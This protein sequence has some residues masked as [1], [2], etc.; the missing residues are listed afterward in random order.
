MA[1][2]IRL[3]RIG[4]KKA[5]CYRIIAVD[6][7]KK[8]DGQY[9]DNLGTYEA[10]TGNFVQLKQDRIDYWI[11]QGA[12]LTD[13]AKKLVKLSK[14]DKLVEKKVKKQVEPIEVKQEVKKVQVKTVKEKK[15]EAAQ[16]EKE[17]PVEE[18]KA[19]S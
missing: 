2:K 13:S 11:S 1:V 12:Q 3:S 6:S 7:R 16:V 10:L 15:E 9:L 19:E 17:A 8:R 18:V 14:Q 5:P 4:K